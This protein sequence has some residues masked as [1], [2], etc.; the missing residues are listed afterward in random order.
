MKPIT[1]IVYYKYKYTY[2]WYKYL[3]H[4]GF[5]FH[6]AWIGNV[7]DTFGQQKKKDNNRYE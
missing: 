5:P 3:N 7:Y 6:K 2:L 1:S 4:T